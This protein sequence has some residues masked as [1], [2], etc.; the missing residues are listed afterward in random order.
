MCLIGERAGQK[1]EKVGR[2]VSQLGSQTGVL[3]VKAVHSIGGPDENSWARRPGTF[4]EIVF[5]GLMSASQEP[6]RRR[7]R[8]PRNREVRPYR[9]IVRSSSLA[10][11][12]KGAA[13]MGVSRTAFVRLVLA[14][15]HGLPWNPLDVDS[16][17]PLPIAVDSEVLR[18]R[19]RSLE[20]HDISRASTTDTTTHIRVDAD[21]A[22]ATEARARRLGVPPPRYIVTVL[23]IA[24]GLHPSFP[25]HQPS[26]LDESG[27]AGP[28]ADSSRRR[29]EGALV[30]C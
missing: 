24:L 18:D 29:Q 16:H 17:L 4:H 7:G 20:Q 12:D 21:V 5:D 9:L 30:A 2:I 23:E 15:A 10:E 28:F 14:E 11:I 27:V 22:T 6:G 8:P 19:A 3:R 13:Q 25:G 26:L 1:V